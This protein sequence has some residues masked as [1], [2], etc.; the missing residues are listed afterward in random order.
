MTKAEQDNLFK[1]AAKV[2]AGYGIYKYFVSPFLKNYDKSANKDELERKA[3]E[4]TY[5]LVN[6]KTGK[7]YTINLE[8]FAT[9]IFDAFHGNKLV[10]DEERAIDILGQVPSQKPNLVL[11]LAN[12]YESNFK[13]NLKQDFVKYL[14]PAQWKRVSFKF[15]QM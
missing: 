13:K 11:V 6:K 8:T 10:E 14:S 4:Y 1:I 2:L 3:K 12:I 5:V 9:V 15:A 7:K